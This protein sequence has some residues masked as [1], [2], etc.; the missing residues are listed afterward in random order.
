MLSFLRENRRILVCTA[1]A[2]AAGL[3]LGAGVDDGADA[4]GGRTGAGRGRGGPHWR[5]VHFAGDAC[6]ARHLLPWL[7]AS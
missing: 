6:G 4:T 2:L 7:S 3:L 5:A 1:L